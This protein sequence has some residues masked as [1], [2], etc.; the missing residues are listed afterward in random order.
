MELIRAAWRWYRRSPLRDAVFAAVMTAITVSGSYGEG[1]PNNP[2]DIVQFHHLPIPH[3]TPA[4]LVLVGA[5]SVVLAWRN[6]WP[7][8][9]LAVSTALV[10][11]YTLLD[12]VNGAA[13]L[14]PAAAVYAVS[15]RVSVP[16]ALAASGV[17]LAVLLTATAAHNPFDSATG[18]SVVVIPALFAAACLGGIAVANR[19]AY[20]ASIRDRALEDAR[21]RVDEER[22]R[23][24]RELHDVVA[25]TMAT[26]NVQAGTAA[27]VVATHP[28]T[29]VE[30]LQA[31]KAASKDGLRELRAILNVLRQAD[32]AEPTQPAPGTAQ[33]ESLVDGARRAGLDTTLTLTGAPF[34]LPA[35]VDLAAYRIIQESLTNVIRHAGPATAAVSVAYCDDALLIDV[36]DTGRGQP[37]ETASEGTGHGLAGM[38]E[39]ATAVGGSLEAGPGPRGGF[40]V[41]ARL[42]LPARTGPTASAAPTAPSVRQGP[43]S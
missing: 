19:R 3:P 40:R 32:E 5:A 2:A 36:C 7:L 39:R 15:T 4:A 31:I 24:A 23:I 38:R 27:H 42:P 12:Y 35:A 33:I 21:R 34:P 25:H 13:L 14:A 37:A 6:R 17:T 10:L 29:A 11:T 22:L 9:V 30:A 20:V 1:H 8:G 28:E 26:I 18:G 43:R 41:A 16:R